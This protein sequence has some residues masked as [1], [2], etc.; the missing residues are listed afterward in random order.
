MEKLNELIDSI[1]SLY[2]K[3]QQK[4]ILEYFRKAEKE[5]HI[6]D[7]PLLLDLIKNGFIKISEKKH[8]RYRLEKYFTE[9]NISSISEKKEFIFSQ[10]PDLKSLKRGKNTSYDDVEDFIL[11]NHVELFDEVLKDF[12]TYDF[13][14]IIG[15]NGH[16]IALYFYRSVG[17]GS[18]YKFNNKTEEWELKND[19]ITQIMQQRGYK[20]EK[21]TNDPRVVTINVD[22]SKTM[23]ECKK[24][25]YI[26]CLKQI[27]ILWF[28]TLFKKNRP[29][30]LT[31]IYVLL[32][33]AFLPYI[34]LFTIIKLLINK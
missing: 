11:K 1:E 33:I 8:I 12:K 24:K 27:G 6:P 10:L 26:E 3:E 25:Y 17:N 31:F 22:L 34:L 7:S 32:F 15:E 13:G 9:N 20:F 21:P 16:L 2:S 28:N 18:N 29:I 23:N 5:S 14:D 4:E 30:W 19:E